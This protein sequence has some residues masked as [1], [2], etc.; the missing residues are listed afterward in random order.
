MTQKMFSSI[1][2]K[3][4]EIV[5]PVF[6][7]NNLSFVKKEIS[8]ATHLQRKRVFEID[9]EEEREREREREQVDRK[10]KYRN[11]IIQVK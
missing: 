10:N 8:W 11:K 1:D 6:F 3:L 7:Q 2:E 9:R 5:N 4:S